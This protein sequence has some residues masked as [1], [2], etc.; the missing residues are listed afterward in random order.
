MHIVVLAPGAGY[1]QSSL[2]SLPETA[3]VTV[4]AWEGKRPD[5]DTVSL[6]RP[7]GLAA[8][9]SKAAAK[10]M[11]GRVLVRLTPLD[12]GATF[13]R[14]T[15]ASAAAREAIR[16]ADVLVAAERDAAYA[17]WRWAKAAARAEATLSAV[18]GYPAGRAA[19]EQVAG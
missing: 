16:S 1:D 3:R 8:R 13:F 10:T 14:A 11:P 7:G 12:P 4:V 5:V 2:G 19:V 15:R 18:Y 6:H 9:V 17:A